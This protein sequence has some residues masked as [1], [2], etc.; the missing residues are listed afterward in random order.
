MG[1]EYN[2]RLLP[3]LFFFKI[4]K[5]LINSGNLVFALSPGQTLLK[6]YSQIIRKKG[7]NTPPVSEVT[8]FKKEVIFGSMLGEITAEKIQLNG[9]TRLRFYMSVVNKELVNHLYSIFKDYVKTKPK[10]I[11]RKHNKLTGKVHSDIYF[12]TSFVISKKYELF[13]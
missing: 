13:N 12:S 2:K 8:N 10:I 9:N 6:Y 1:L 11:I 5:S 4:Y 3:L 7:P